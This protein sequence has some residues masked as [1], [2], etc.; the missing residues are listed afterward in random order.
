VIEPFG[1]GYRATDLPPGLEDVDVP[2][3]PLVLLAAR[4]GQGCHSAWK[5]PPRCLAT[6]RSAIGRAEPGLAAGT[7][8]G[9]QFGDEIDL[10]G[11]VK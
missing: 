4:E 7:I 11:L 1:S 10:R 3:I 5:W 9:F 6:F 2:A 8:F